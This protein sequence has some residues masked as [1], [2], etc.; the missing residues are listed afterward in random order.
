MNL[1]ISGRHNGIT[2]ALTPQSNQI[3]LD[4]QPNMVRNCCWFRLEQS[5]CCPVSAQ[6]YWVSDSLFKEMTFSRRYLHT[7]L[8]FMSCGAASLAWQHSRIIYLCFT[9]FPSRTGIHYLKPHLTQSPINQ[10]VDG[11]C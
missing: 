10:I 7:N 6:S 8:C 1:F 3:A 11:R 5:H 9:H 4:H 2:S